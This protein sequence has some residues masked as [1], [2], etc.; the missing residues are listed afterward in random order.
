MKR[1]REFDYVTSAVKVSGS[2][3]APDGY[4]QM[5]HGDEVYFLARGNVVEV[6]FPEDK[7]GN[8]GRVAKIKL[9]SG[10]IVD[11]EQAE[12]LTAEQREKQTGQGSIIAEIGRHVKAVKPASRVETEPLADDDFDIEPGD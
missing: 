2:V 11:P 10:F 3:P 1:A 12:A 6:S 5:E 8:I 4:D 7:D 9:D